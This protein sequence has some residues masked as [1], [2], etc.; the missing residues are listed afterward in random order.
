M[1]SLCGAC[2]CMCM[3]RACVW[4]VPTGGSCAPSS[5]FSLFLLLLAPPISATRHAR[6]AR[7][8][9]RTHA[10]TAMATAGEGKG[11]DEEPRTYIARREVKVPCGLEIVVDKIAKYEGCS[12]KEEKRE[13][14]DEARRE[15]GS[16][17]GRAA[18]SNGRQYCGRAPMRGWLRG[19]D[20][21]PKG[22]APLRCVAWQTAGLPGQSSRDLRARVLVFSPGPLLEPQGTEGLRRSRLF[23]APTAAR[24]LPTRLPSTHDSHSPVSTASSPHSRPMRGSSSHL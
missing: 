13:G 1:L 2:V 21:P 23:A 4:C 9:I 18:R 16:G 19:T 11:D 3:A 14:D 10:P 24:H 7:P 12:G 15:G 22:I 17:G 8:Q 20:A 5:V 6:R